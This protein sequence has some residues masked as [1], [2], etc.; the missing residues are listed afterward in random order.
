MY[1]HLVLSRQKAVA[2]SQLI[3][4]P[5]FDD[6]HVFYEVKLRKKV[7]VHDIRKKKHKIYIPP[8]IIIVCVKKE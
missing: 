2:S 7:V 4:F 6:V 8:C 5:F 1:F 3:D